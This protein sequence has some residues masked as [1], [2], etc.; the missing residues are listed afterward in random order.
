MTK[1]ETEQNAGVREANETVNPEVAVGEVLT[2]A[3]VV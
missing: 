2:V 1:P 3:P